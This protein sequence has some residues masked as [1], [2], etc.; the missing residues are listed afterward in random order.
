MQSSNTSKKKST[1]SE[2]GSA[3]HRKSSSP[4]KA[5]SSPAVKSNTLGAGSNS[6]SSS[7]IDSVGVMTPVQRSSEVGT[8]STEISPSHEE[9]AKLAHSYWVARGYHSGSPEQDW[10]RA[11]RE[12]KAKR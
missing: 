6:V 10:L 3:K 4:E 9:I 12:L 7:V 5:E 8:K 11:E 2:T 1:T